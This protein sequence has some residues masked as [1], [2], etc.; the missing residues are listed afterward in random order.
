[1]LQ[2]HVAGTLPRD[3]SHRVNARFSWKILLRGRN[4]VPATCP[5]N[6]NQFELRG[7]VAATKQRYTPVKRKIASCELLMRH[8]ENRPIR[9]RNHD[10]SLRQDPPCEHF[11]KP[12][13]ATCPF[14]WTAH[15]ILPRDMSLQHVPSCEPTFRVLVISRRYNK[16]LESISYLNSSYA[17]NYCRHFTIRFCWIV[18]RPRTW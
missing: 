16:Q 6:S 10:M 17:L 12:I 2:G 7:R 9:K 14:V 5:L 18:Q 15:E 13:P 1:M 3:K 4:F 8:S 11:K